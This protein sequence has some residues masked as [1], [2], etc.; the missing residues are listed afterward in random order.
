[1][2]QYGVSALKV[3]VVGVSAL[4]S[5]GC[6]G[7]QMPD[8]VMFWRGVDVEDQG[9]YRS[10]LINSVPERGP[11]W[12]PQQH[13]PEAGTS[14]SPALGT[15]TPTM[16]SYRAPRPG[17]ATEL[18]AAWKGVEGDN[19][20]YWTTKQETLPFREPL[21]FSS[22]YG[23][24]LAVR[25][26]RDIFLA[27]RGTNDDQSIFWAHNDLNRGNEDDASRG[28]EHYG[29]IPK[30]GT[31]HKPA[32]T[33]YHAFLYAAW[34]G[35]AGDSGIYVSQFGGA[36]RDQVRV[37][38]VGTNWAPAIVGFKDALHMVWRGVGKDQGIYHSSSSDSGI[39]WTPQEQI[40]NAGTNYGPAITATKTRLYLA[41]RGIEGDQSLYWSWSY[42]G[43]S[44]FDQQRVPDVG[45]RFGPALAI[46]DS[47]IPRAN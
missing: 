19:R 44:W 22:S 29:T 23:P 9:V 41:W 38:D 34:K 33:Y 12:E 20:L 26:S 43:A 32:L 15:F 18:Y 42:D 5:L 14:D 40:P 16:L 35:I 13:L 30:A 6:E 3:A 45:S 25:G 11:Y 28:W 8:V 1:M 4:L 36:W 46:D 2:K 21:P 39:T 47:D 7:E 31:S 24:A 10:S 17:E 27:W 37:P